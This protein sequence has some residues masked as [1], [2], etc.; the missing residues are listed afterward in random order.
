MKKEGIGDIMENYVINGK[1]VT[2]TLDDGREVKASTEYLE[3]MVKN[4]DID[5]EEAV[6]TWLEDEEYLINEEQEELN[7]ATKGTRVGNV[8]GAKAEK[9]KTQKE[10][11][12]KEN[13]TKEM[14]IA[15]IAKVLPNFAE[16]VV[17]ENAGKLITFTIGEDMFKIDLVQKRKP[18]TK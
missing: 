6:L 15:E 1:V 12:K 8:I 14:I 17:V 16:N 11:A 18:K 5:M 2:I 3:N 9:P 4:L 10:R 7:K 13:P